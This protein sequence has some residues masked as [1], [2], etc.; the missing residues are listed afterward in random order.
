LGLSARWVAPIALT[1]LLALTLYPPWAYTYQQSG[2]SQVHEPAPR[3]LL[4][5]PPPKSQSLPSYC[6]CSLDYG[7]LAAEWAAV[8]LGAVLAVL[9]LGTFQGS[10]GISALRRCA[11][12]V[13]AHRKFCVGFGAVVV[14]TI[15]VAFS[16]PIILDEKEQQAEPAAVAPPAPV[17]AAAPG[18]D[19]KFYWVNLG[20]R[21][22]HP[23]ACEVYNGTPRAL[24]SLTVRVVWRADGQLRSRDVDPWFSYTV[25]PR[26]V[27]VIHFDVGIDERDF[28][29]AEIV[30]AKFEP[31]P[32]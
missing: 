22:P 10:A 24:T 32:E 29:S 18:L 23:L 2:M 20:G 9:G 15:G 12:W 4:W 25:L 7:R 11:V 31:A 8:L 14:C 5:A 30:G 13:G 27:G 3:A 19:H 21:Y 16:V 26:R 1:A 17:L 6:G 28:V